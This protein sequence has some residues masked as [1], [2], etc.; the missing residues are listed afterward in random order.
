MSGDGMVKPGQKKLKYSITLSDF[1]SG[2]CYYTSKRRLQTH[3]HARKQ[4]AAAW[5]LVLVELYSLRRS[6]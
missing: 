5:G 1:G 6:L 2:S 3:V 4:P